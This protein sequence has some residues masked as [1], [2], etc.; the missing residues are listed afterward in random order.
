MTWQPYKALS[1]DESLT[2][3][4]KFVWLHFINTDTKYLSC[5]GTLR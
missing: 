1:F 2:W 5:F 4:V 3:Y